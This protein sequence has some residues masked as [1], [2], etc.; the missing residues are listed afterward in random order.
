MTVSGL[1]DVPGIGVDRMGDLADAAGDPGLL[2]LENLDTD[3]RPPEVA[4]AATRR[5]VSRCILALRNH[6]LS[7]QPSGTAESAPATAPARATNTEMTSA[8]ISSTV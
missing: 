6:C 8:A 1:R 3:L 7:C 5:E 2:R 4:L